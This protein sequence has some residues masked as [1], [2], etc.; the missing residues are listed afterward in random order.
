[1]HRHCKLLSQQRCAA[2]RRKEG[3]RPNKWGETERIELNDG[4]KDFK[5]EGRKRQIGKKI[6]GEHKEKCQCHRE[7]KGRRGSS[8]LRLFSHKNLCER[9]RERRGRE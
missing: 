2:S 5:D 6:Y 8:G 1:M 7:V 9:V 4:M 3:K